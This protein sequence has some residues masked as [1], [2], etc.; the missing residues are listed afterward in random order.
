MDLNSI[1]SAIEGSKPVEKAGSI[2]VDAILKEFNIKEDK[3]V[4][5]AAKVNNPYPENTYD[6]RPSVS[7]VSKESSDELKNTRQKKG[8]PTES[9]DLTSPSAY[10]HHVAGKEMFSSGVEDLTTGH[11]YK[12][13]AKTAF[14]G[15]MVAGAPASGIIEDTIGKYGNKLGPG[16][17]DR[18]AVIASGAVPVVPGAGAAI[19]ILPKTKS[20]RTLVENIGPENIPMVVKEMKAN[21]RLAPADLSPRVLQDAQHLFANDGP[22][23]N[24]LKNTSDARMASRRSVMEEAYDTAGGISPNLA[25]K[26]TDLA[27][28]AKK[29]GN[30]K[31]QPALN[32]AKPVDISNTLEAIDATLKPGVLKIGDSVPLTEVKKQLI[33][34]RNDLRASKEYDAKD[35][36][37][38]Q[39]GLRETAERLMRSASGS[40]QSVGKALMDVRNSLVSDID[41]SAKGYKEALSSYR[42]EM[43]ITEAFKEGHD[44]IFNSSK[45]I[46]NDPSFTKKWFDGLSNYEK[47]A[48][49]EGARAAIYTEMGVAKNPALAGESI[50]R[51]DFNKA[52][53]EILFGKEETD[54]LL[55]TLNDERT[56]ANTHN[57]IVEGSQTAMRAASKA[58]FALPTA[59]QV[60]STLLPASIVEGANILAG[61]IGGLGTA[62]YMGLKGGNAAKDAIKMKLAREH[63]AQYAKLALPTEGPSRDELIR[64][65]EAFIPQ[66]KMTMLNKIRASLPSKP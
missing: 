42:D 1:I 27:N 44:K 22:Q 34:I 50:A 23:I 61:G 51:S 7:G 63:N 10:E 38:F 36:H 58:Q 41:K 45:K 13:L 2:D 21:P 28:A 39:S 54:K 56:I 60:G 46:E 17:G 53:M 15:L 57:K 16:F 3:P 30:E 6:P 26:I 24:Y 66:P 25:Q 20:L 35:L 64:Q 65:L 14:G 18:A 37:R 31:I 12:G 52:K 43:H 29:V 9:F 62:A 59:T 4:A 48:A 40:D 47:Q 49:R 11:P 33:N 8:L 19:K 5:K 32:A 55:K